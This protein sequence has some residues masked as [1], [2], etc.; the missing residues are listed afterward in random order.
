MRRNTRAKTVTG[1]DS[2]FY[3]CT[4]EYLLILDYSTSAVAAAANSPFSG[5]DSAAL[6]CW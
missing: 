2:G 6:S 5:G 3:Q 4:G 1:D